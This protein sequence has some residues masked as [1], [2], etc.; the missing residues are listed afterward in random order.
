MKGNGSSTSFFSQ[1]NNFNIYE[2]TDSINWTLNTTIDS[3]TVL[4]SGS[5]DSLSVKFP[6]TSTTAYLKFYYQKFVGNV[7]FDNLVITGLPEG[8]ASAPINEKALVIYPNPSKGF[9]N[10]DLRTVNHKNNMISVVL[11]N[12]LGKEVKKSSM[13]STV[14]CDG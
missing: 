8:I 7:A 12:V 11:Y 2:S 5:T 13:K 9:V 14:I 10:I 1:Q 3:M 4:P 6:L